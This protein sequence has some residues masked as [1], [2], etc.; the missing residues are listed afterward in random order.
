MLISFNPTV[1][2]FAID[3]VAGT[4]HCFSSTCRLTRLLNLTIHHVLGGS[5]EQYRHS[6]AVLSF[7]CRLFPRFPLCPPSACL[8]LSDSNS[9]PYHLIGPTT[10]R[11]GLSR[12]LRCRG[13]CWRL[14]IKIL[15]MN[16]K[17]TLFVLKVHSICTLFHHNLSIAHST[18]MERL[19]FATTK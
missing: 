4:F 17:L 19:A 5:Y 16:Y 10:G 6:R 18:P 3:L 12:P 7:A 8:V 1:T 9:F 11:N 2:F 13:C 15:C 14:Y